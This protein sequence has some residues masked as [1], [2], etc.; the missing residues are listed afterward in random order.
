MKRRRN[1]YIYQNSNPLPLG[2][3]Y[4]KRIEREYYD[5]LPVWQKQEALLQ[6]ILLDQPSEKAEVFE[7]VYEGEGLTFLSRACPFELCEEQGLEIEDRGE[8]G[9]LITA[10]RRNASVNLAFEGLENSET[11][12]RLTGISYQP[13]KDTDEEPLDEIPIRISC[14]GETEE[15]RG[16]E[17]TYYTPSHRYYNGHQDYFV[18]LG[19]RKD[20]RDQL[21]LSFPLPGSYYFSG[22]EV[23]CQPMDNYE[24]LLNER[25]QS[26][27]ERID[28]HANQ[29]YALSEV[30][31]SVNLDEPKLLCLAMPFSEGWSAWVDEEQEELLQA[32]TMY[33]ALPL[34]AGEHKI[35]LVYQTPGSRVGIF[36]TLTG[37]FFFVILQLF[38]R[39]PGV[40]GRMNEAAG[41]FVDA[42]HIE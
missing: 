18:N 26:V 9:I 30:T 27:L 14:F 19:Y 31:G 29:S 24:Q 32:N 10:N 23:I 5:S 25:K 7:T 42:Y 17:L 12:L 28:L 16:K 35:R 39:R 40:R 15:E 4:E 6:G 13:I 22:M 37:W 38:S 8:K 1:I 20:P 3:T 2:Y 21:R 41:T 34:D 33:M 36:L 11:C